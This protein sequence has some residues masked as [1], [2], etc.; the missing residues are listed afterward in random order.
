M[1][2]SEINYPNSYN[3]E[4]ILDL[5]LEAYS[6]YV[7][8]HPGFPMLHDYVFIPGYYNSTSDVFV[9]DSSGNQVVDGSGNPV[10]VSAT[11]STD[12]ITDSRREN[13]KLL[14]SLGTNF[15]LAEYWDYSFY[16]WV[17][18]DG[19]GENFDSYLVT[20]YNLAGDM[21]R[22]KQVIYLQIFCKRT[23]E[24]Y[25]TVGGSVVLDKQSSCYV[26]SQWNWCEDNTQGKWG[27]PFQAYRFLLPQPTAPADGDPF[28][29]GNTV[30]KTK[31]K[32]R[33]R[34]DALSLYVYSEAGKDMKLLGW[35]TLVT[36]NGEP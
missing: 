26:Q 18:V 32:L 3:R 21:A 24:N 4:L 9:Y 36:I 27:T 34:G 11:Y 31:N 29:Y 33:G 8:N 6:V 7:I 35:N 23:E 30:I 15:S 2:V 10:T 19:V 28:D 1:A 13:F 5:T 16:D 22:K 25:T 14:I 20:G 12:R 17:T